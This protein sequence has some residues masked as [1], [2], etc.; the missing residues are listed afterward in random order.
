MPTT[1]KRPLQRRR[2]LAITQVLAQLPESDPV[3][4]MRCQ[5]PT[6]RPA[7]GVRLDPR[8]LGR[9]QTR[10]HLEPRQP[11]ATHIATQHP[12][13]TP[14]GQLGDVAR[15]HAKTE[16]ARSRVQLMSR[17]QLAGALQIPHRQHRTATSRHETMSRLVNHQV[18]T[19]IVASLVL[20]PKPVTTMLTRMLARQKLLDR[21]RQ[22]PRRRKRRRVD[23]HATSDPQPRP[24]RIAR[25]HTKLANPD[26]PR[27]VKCRNQNPSR[28]RLH[29][30]VQNQPLRFIPGN[31]TRHTQPGPQTTTQHTHQ[32]TTKT[33]QSSARK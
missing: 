32:Q 4:R 3:T 19:V 29:V 5:E 14:T 12:Q 21:L 1:S 8:M 6:V 27:R 18:T 24:T 33:S 25:R 28:R 20:H 22:Q 16:T 23:H 11:P 15:H 2:K 26:L 13:S 17:I 30:R 10:Y 9:P 31:L 7:P